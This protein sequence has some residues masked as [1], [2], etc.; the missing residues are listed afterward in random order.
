MLC[1]LEWHA[2]Q[3]WPTETRL[4][5]RITAQYTKTFGRIQFRKRLLC[6][7]NFCV[8]NF[9]ILEVV[10]ILL[11]NPV[12]WCLFPLHGNV[13][14][15]VTELLGKLHFGAIIVTKAVETALL[16]ETLST[17]AMPVLSKWSFKRCRSLRHFTVFALVVVYVLLI[18][19]HFDFRCV[20]GLRTRFG[21]NIHNK[22]H[23]TQKIPK[24]AQLML[25]VLKI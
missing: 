15:S 23:G 7:Q 2:L 10:Y 13:L 17:H 24:Q 1:N 8:R 21:H 19:L 14:L 11:V 12:N 22:K 18:Q 9:R 25:K 3:S 6:E 4:L 16:S 20:R 5:K